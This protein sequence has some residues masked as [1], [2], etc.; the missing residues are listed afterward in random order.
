[1]FSLRLFCASC[2]QGEVHIHA[3]E[4]RS[5]CL[6]M[7]S[8]KDFRRCHECCLIA[9]VECQKHNHQCDYGLA[10]S[11]IALKQS[12]HLVT[13]LQIGANLLD[14]TFLGV[15]ER[16]GE[17]FLVKS[18]EI[19]ANLLKHN[20]SG[21]YLTVFFMNQ[22]PQLEEEMFLIFQPRRSTLNISAVRRQMNLVIG[23]FSRQELVVKN[24]TFGQNFR[25]H[26]PHLQHTSFYDFC[27][28]FCAETGVFHL[29]GGVVNALQRLADQHIVGVV[30]LNVGMCEV[31]AV[32]KNARL[33]ENKVFLAWLEAV[34]YPFQ[35]FKPHQFDGAGVVGKSR[36]NPCNS[37]STNALQITHGSDELVINGVVT[38]LPDLMN[39][40]TV[41]IPERE[42]IHEVLKRENAQLLIQQLSSFRPHALQ[43]FYFC[44]Q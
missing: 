12:A 17:V 22:K 14:D 33:A 7:L 25:N 4:L 43:K 1:M 29:L 16:E 13:A 2:E 34:F 39:L 5:Q 30:V 6:K 27:E 40:R 3:F 21:V 41:D 36:C 26:V 35:T 20:A 37:R 8:S 42:I 38:N 24:Q 11:D 31:E 32:V 18:V 44:L 10:A 23:F 15:G 19:I 9:V 28:L